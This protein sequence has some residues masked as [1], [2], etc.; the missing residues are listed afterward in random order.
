MRIERERR[1][2]AKRAEAEAMA[3][4]LNGKPE[5]LGPCPNCGKRAGELKESELGSRFPFYVKCNACGWSTSMVRLESVAVKV[6]NE[7]KA[8]KSAKGKR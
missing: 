5:R 4:T 3:E 2:S 8:P 6:W 7:A 1:F